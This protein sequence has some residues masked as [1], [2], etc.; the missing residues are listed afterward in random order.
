M[1]LVAFVG[2]SG[3]GKSHRA[4]WVAREN[5]LDYIIDDGLLIHENSIVAGKS[6]K[7][8]PSKISSVKVALFLDEDHQNDI[9]KA[10]KVH[11]PQG[12][13]VLGTSDGM[14]DKIATVLEL[15]EYDQRIYIEDVASPYEIEQA[16]N[17]RI[18][19]GKHV[20]PV[21]AMQLKKQFSGY[22]LD[23]LQLFRRKGKGQFQNIGEKS[24]VRPTF[25]YFGNY[26]ISDYA[27]YQLVNYIIAIM[28]QMDKVSRFRTS[29]G[30]DGLYI[31]MDVIMVFGYNLLE[32]VKTAREQIIKELDRFAGF[33]VNVL[34]INVKSLVFIKSPPDF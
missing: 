9:K 19:Q 29:N 25:S 34:N 14:V 21:P 31:D 30:P 18:K 24:V 20:I 5:N 32:S 33:N 27:I 26:M 22:F 4:L 23:P 28:P 2:S 16:K 11:E 3:S 12:I 8:A 1:K 7:K 10:I 6:A 17:T 15:G 13:L